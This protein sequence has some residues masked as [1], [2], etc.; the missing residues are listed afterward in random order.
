MRAAFKLWVLPLLAAG[1]GLAS[2][3]P[4]K[5][6][7]EARLTVEDH[8]GLFTPEAVKRAKA[9][10]AE[11]K[12]PMARELTV[13]TFKEIPAARKADFEK[14]GKDDR[15]ARKRFFTEWARQEAKEDRAKGIFVLVCRS[16]G[17]IQV[18]IDR[19]TREHGFNQENE[20]RLAGL[21]LERFRE[22]AKVKS[23][24]EQQALRDKA[25]V[26]AAEYVRDALRRRSG[27]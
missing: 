2:A 16:P 20:D 22:A 9:V 14:I 5:P 6:M 3:A 17:Y 18:L 1:F 15:E 19:A 23:E 10:L 8:A 21:L 4:P 12:L 24:S 11:V 27:K 25:L 13:V 7:I 26:Q